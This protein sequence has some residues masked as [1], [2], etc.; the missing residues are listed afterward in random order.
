MPPLVSI[1]IPAFNAEPWIADTIR[2]ALAQT[3]PRTEVIVVDDGS[4]DRTLAIA[5]RFE[6]KQVHVVPQANAGAAAARNRA[7]ALS[8]GDWVQWLDADDLLSAD[9]I[10][11]Q[12][13]VAREIGNPRLLLSSAWGAFAYRPETAKFGPCL[14]WADRDPV[15]WLLLQLEH[16]LHMQTA[17]WLVSR[18]LTDAAGPWDAQLASCPCDDGE[19]FSRV[20][21]ASDGIR[22]VPGA[23]VFYRMAA[24][25]RQSDVGS[26]ER[27]MNAYLLGL[28]LYFEHLTARDPSERARAAC[29]KY[30]Q[31]SLA[32][33]YREESRAFKRAQEL[34]AVYGG[35]VVPPR[36]SWK[37]R[38]IQQVFGWDAARRAQRGYNRWKI[39][40]RTSWDKAMARLNERSRPIPGAP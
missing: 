23:K 30:L 32:D 6:S 21:L 22:F 38:W 8:Q 4:R 26:S 13:A 1:L 28:S 39:A 27:K 10:A 16:N 14:L 20:I 7:L 18:E 35:Q 33:Y 15:E 36:L 3:W 24:G 29:V 19:Y 37:Y 5:R 40:V 34:A 11:R 25:D 17:T 31:T 12:M 9:K 2:S